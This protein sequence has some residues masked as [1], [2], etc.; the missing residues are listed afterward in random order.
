MFLKQ[1]AAD[2]ASILLIMS[3]TVSATPICRKPMSL[4]LNNSSGT[5]MRSLHRLRI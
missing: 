5:Q 1:A 2:A 4:G 3:A